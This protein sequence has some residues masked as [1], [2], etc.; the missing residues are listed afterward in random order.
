MVDKYLEALEKIADKINRKDERVD[1]ALTAYLYA[2]NKIEK[3]GP[4]D[5]R[6]EDNRPGRRTP[7]S[8]RDGVR[9][10]GRFR[11]AREQAT[12]HCPDP[13]PEARNPGPPSLAVPTRRQ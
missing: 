3:T 8:L 11:F 2:I 12:T 6:G 1:A 9:R 7:A 5:G 10:F 4:Q 13:F